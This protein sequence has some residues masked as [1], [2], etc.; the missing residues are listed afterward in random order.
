MPESLSLIA[1]FSMGLFGSVHCIGMCG[2]IVT[3]LT[4]NSQTEKS[5]TKLNR[6]L[7][8]YNSGRILSYSLAG[9][10]VA[11]IGSQFIAQLPEPQ[12]ISRY[13]NAAVLILLGLYLADWWRIL[14]LLERAGSYVWRI[15]QPLGK[16]LLPVK[17]S[18]HAFLLGMLWGWLPC[19]L[20]YSTLALSLTSPTIWQGSLIMLVFGLGT[21]PMLLLMGHL[22]E[23]LNQWRQKV[24]VRRIAGLLLIGFGIS[25][26]LMPHQ[27]GSGSDTQQQTHSHHH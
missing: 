10:L 27:H 1:A 22:A 5:T 8:A 7:L 26:L 18:R 17:N 15:I 19:G 13:L 12:N 25:F 6:Y 23:Q 3:T 21:L 4:F 11:L 14:T 2:G 9:L 24:W 16:N 20:V